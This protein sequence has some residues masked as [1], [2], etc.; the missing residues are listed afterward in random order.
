MVAIIG[1]INKMAQKFD[2]YIN[3]GF[4]RPVQVFTEIP[5][6]DKQ[7]EEYLPQQQVFI[8][9]QTTQKVH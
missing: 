6:D 2:C 9:C 1:K 8:N 3:T 5:F 4:R 7:L